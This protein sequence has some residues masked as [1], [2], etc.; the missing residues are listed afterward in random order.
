MGRAPRICCPSAMAAA[1]RG[2]AEARV[3]RGQ[4]CGQRES[5]SEEDAASLPVWVTVQLPTRQGRQWKC[6]QGRGPEANR[7]APATKMSQRVFLPSGQLEGL[8][9]TT[10]Y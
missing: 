9:A 8:E 3:S 2:K 1:C 7:R 4:E 6:G 5:L 10:S